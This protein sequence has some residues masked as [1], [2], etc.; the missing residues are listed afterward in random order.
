MTHP[1]CLAQQSQWLLI[2]L[3]NFL[4]NSQLVSQYFE[5]LPKFSSPFSSFGTLTTCLFMM[6]MKKTCDEMIK[7]REFCPSD[8]VRLQALKV[9]ELGVSDFG[10]LKCE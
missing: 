8:A 3:M 6:Y 1:F 5:V 10:G 2:W 7:L 4:E 9:G